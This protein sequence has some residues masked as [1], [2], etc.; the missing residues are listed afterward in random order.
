MGHAGQELRVDP[1]Q[2]ADGHQHRQ[3]GAAR[4]GLD[5]LDR[6]GRRP[7][8]RARSWSATRCTSSRRSRTSLYAF[9]LSKPGAPMQVAATTRSRSRASQGVACCDLVN[10]GAAYADGLVF[11][12]TLD[13]RTIALDAATGQAKWITQLADINKGETITMAP[14][15][16]KGKVLVGNSGGEFG[17]RGWLTALDAA[18]GAGRCGAP[19]APA[20]T[21]T[22]SSARTSSRSTPAIAA[23]ISA[24]RPGRAR[25]GAPAAARSGAGSPTTRSSN[26]IYYGTSN[27]GPWNPE[28]RPG[29]NKWTAGM[30]AR[31]PETGEARWFYQ[32]SPHDLF[33]HDGVNELVLVDLEMAGG[34]TQDRAARRSQR[35]PLRHRSNQRRG[36]VGDAVRVRQLEPRRRHEDRT[37]HPGR[38][39]GDEARRGGARH[40]PGGAGHEGLAADVVL[41]AT[42]AC[43]TSRTRTSA[44]TS[45]AW[46]PATSPARRS[47]APASSTR[48]A[49]ADTAACSRRGIRW[50]R[51]RSWEIKETVPGLERHGRHRR[52][53]RLL[54]H[55][56]RLVQGGRRA[57]RRR[58]V[59]VQVRLGDHRSADRLPRSGR[60]RIRGGA[61]GSR[62][63]GRRDRQQR[64]RSARR[65]G[66]QRLGR[67][68]GRPEGGDALA[69]ACSTCSRSAGRTHEAAAHPGRRAGDRSAA[70]RRRHAIAPRRGSL[71]VCAD[72]NNLPYSN[73]AGDGFENRI[74]DL[75]ASDRGARLEYTWWAQRR[76]FLRNTLNAGAC[77]VVMGVPTGTAAVADDPAV[78]S[79][80]LRL[81]LAPR[82]ATW[83]SRR[84]TIRGCAACASASR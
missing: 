40:L 60:P 7:R 71:R 9:D 16:V 32:T 51:R 70:G 84:S 74:A 79:L 55:D 2:R 37:A 69:A 75:L 53:S 57:D 15:V 83:T 12:N 11:F 18:S 25:A 6:H 48:P 73:A 5:L 47:S 63:L 30:F 39:E 62:R 36:A 23:R 58:A 49:P 46:R 64:P 43:S 42:P 65:H 76:G 56:G 28:Q 67:R 50:Q 68:D 31:V 59:A 81:R 14:L 66:R 20:P 17:V 1:V 33:D 61:L 41:A 77:D 10:R 38:R 82:V 34:V 19:T 35:P 24:S 45:R 44:R 52:R 3:R 22:S 4:R 80:E 78:L 13:G 8:S 72:P 27:P 26:L 29:D 21:R 54:R